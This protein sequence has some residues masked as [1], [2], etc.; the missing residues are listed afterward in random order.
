ML[1]P[2]WPDWVIY[3]ALGKFLKPFAA[4]YLPKSLTFLWNVNTADLLRCRHPGMQ[5]LSNLEKI[6]NNFNSSPTFGF[7]VTIPASF[8]FIFVLSTANSKWMLYKNLHMTGFELWTSAVGS[9][10]SAHWATA[11][12]LVYFLSLNFAVAKFLLVKSA[13]FF[14]RKVFYWS[15]IRLE[16]SEDW[17]SKFY[18]RQVILSECWC[19][20]LFPL[21]QC[22]Q[23]ARLFVYIWR[24]TTMQIFT[25][26]N[27]IAKA[28]K[29][30]Q[31]VNSPQ[32][33]AKSFYNRP[34][35]RNFA[36]SG[37]IVTTGETSVL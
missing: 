1:H 27:F 20:N 21:S 19:G 9:N 28:G 34:K 30:C 2:A 29:F 8:F 33:I 15:K 32:E 5:H 37:H 7:N 3:C 26:A 22:D 10:S 11:T 16:R 36:K 18:T 12:S 13:L 6:K 23:M 14:L 4:I 31:I 24:L 17:P 25:I 35:W